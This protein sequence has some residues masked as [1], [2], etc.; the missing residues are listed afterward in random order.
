VLFKQPVLTTPF[1]AAVL[2]RDVR[3]LDLLQS[4]GQIGTERAALVC[5]AL[6]IDAPG[7]ASHLTPGGTFEC[8][9]GRT[10]ASLLAR[11]GS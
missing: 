9:A 10:F 2:A 6:D 7:V 11:P 5:L 1:E 3:M 4:Y 8:E